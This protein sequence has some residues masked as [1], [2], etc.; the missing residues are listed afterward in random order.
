MA[1][2]I[3]S[4]YSE[5]R[6]KQSQPTPNVR[7]IGVQRRGTLPA[8]APSS[9]EQFDSS[10]VRLDRIASRTA[11]VDSANKGEKNR[12]EAASVPGFLHGSRPSPSMNRRFPLM[13][14]GFQKPT[15][16][17]LSA[18]SDLR[19]RF[20]SQM[21]ILNCFISGVVHTRARAQEEPVG[22]PLPFD[23]QNH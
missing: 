18:I 5:T 21:F 7:F 15:R 9:W 8:N 16:K 1:A 6:S 22:F 20:P 11:D 4:D 14:S 13:C 19:R 23:P 10:L 12:Q 17:K 2:G 3:K